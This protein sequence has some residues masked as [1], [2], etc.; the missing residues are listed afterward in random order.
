[1]K[2]VFLGPPGAGKGTLAALAKEA[3]G[4]VHISTGDIF[5]ANIKGGTPLGMKVKAIL[6]TGGLVP[7]EITVEIVED[8]LKKPD[9]QA[10][11][12]L[13]GFPRTVGQAESLAAFDS[14]DAVIN[15]E[16]SAAEITKRL[17]GRRTCPNCGAGYHVTSLPPKVDGVCD[18]CGSKLVRRPDDEPEAI[19]RRQ[20]V[21]FRETQPLIDWYKNKG[22]L[23][24]VD[25][26][27]S[28]EAI[29]DELKAILKK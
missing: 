10:G 29:L 22:L 20:R 18:K 7:D 2:L 24:N 12:L 13:D 28:P 19:E 1:M 21:Y 8:R 5:R 17:S 14:I 27:P 11:Y 26:S 4:V 25:A 9:A 23:K 16:L 15:F 6:D 3:F